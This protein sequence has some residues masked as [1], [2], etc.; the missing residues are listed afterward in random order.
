MARPTAAGGDLAARLLEAGLVLARELVRKLHERL[1]GE[2]LG[3]LETVG[4]GFIPVRKA[5]KSVKG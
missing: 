1:I 3:L 5:I 2:D 4:G